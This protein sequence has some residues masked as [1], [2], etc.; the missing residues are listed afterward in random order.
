MLAWLVA[1][2][3]PRA[4]DPHLAMGF[5]WPIQPQPGGGW[6]PLTS[7]CSIPDPQQWKTIQTTTKGGPK[8][9]WEPYFTGLPA[10]PCTMCP[11]NPGGSISAHAKFSALVLRYT[12]CTPK[13]DFSPQQ[14]SHPVR[15]RQ[16][17]PLLSPKFPMA[18]G[19]SQEKADILTSAYKALLRPAPGLPSVLAF[20]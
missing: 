16:T 6:Q 5:S 17:L 13:C 1:R 12:H 20:T 18:P 9:P 7:C 19:S 3:S 8:P 11:S 14:Q 15:K 10:L 4:S 2:T